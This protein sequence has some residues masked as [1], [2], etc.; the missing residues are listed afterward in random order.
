M[1]SGDINGIG[2]RYCPSIEDKV[3]RFA[4]HP[5]HL[6]MLEP[7]WRDSNQIY[8][9]GFSTS[10]SE[11]VQLEALRKIPAL[12]NVEFLRPG[13]AIEYD[14]I[15]PKQHKS[16]LESKWLSG[17][18]FAGQVNGTSGYEEAAGQGL[19]AGINAVAR[20]AETEP[21]ILGRD[22]AY[23]GVLIDDLITKDTLEPY[24]MFTSRAEFRLLLR[25]SNADTRL[26]PYARKYRLLSDEHLSFLESKLRQTSR[27]L[28]KLD[29]SL[30]PKDINPILS[31]RQAKPISQKQPA[32]KLLKRPEVS[33]RDL[34][35]SALSFT[36]EF[37]PWI[38]DEIL[39]EV[40]TEIKYEGYIHRQL[41]QIQK[42]SRNET[43]SLPSQ[44]DYSSLTGLSNEAREKLD[45]IRPETLGQAMRIQGVSP[46]D[47][48]VLSVYLARQ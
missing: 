12:K 23:L 7:E 46:A 8:A 1:Y 18:F 19:I 33:I 5:K 35:S 47:I 41:Q 29:F 25:F 30:T 20:N 22:E 14:F 4:H 37:E 44:M 31:S 17:L 16:T 26:L 39:G 9:N 45:S 36:E 10:L 15:P 38:R 3:Y 48:A 6:I 2:P 34:P 40:E 27:I 11:W 28:D 21:L 24:R 43:Y 42:A 32:K 13:Y